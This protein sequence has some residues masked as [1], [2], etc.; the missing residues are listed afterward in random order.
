MHAD[1]NHFKHEFW[2]F[3]SEKL[4]FLH[5]DILYHIQIPC[6]YSYCYQWLLYLLAMFKICAHGPTQESGFG[7]IYDF[8]HSE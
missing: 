7:N 5:W 1:A 3:I 8:E 6:S 4:Q 2:N